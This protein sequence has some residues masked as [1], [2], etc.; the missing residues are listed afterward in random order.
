MHLPPPVDPLKIVIDENIPFGRE[1][2]GTLAAVVSLPGRA[3]EPKVVR[4]AEILVVRS[5]TQVDAALLQHS[6][7][8]FVGTATAGCDHIDRDYLEKNHILF[9]SAEGANAN[10]VAEYVLAALLMRARETETPLRGLSLGIIGVGHI[11]TR[12][13][14]KAAAI[15]MDIILNDPP[16]R[17]KTG[18]ACYRSFKEACEADFITL[19]VPLIQE[20][21]DTTRNLFDEA[22]IEKLSP[23]TLVVNTS[24]GEVVDN[25]AFLRAVIRERLAPPVFDVWENEPAINWA[26]LRQSGISTPHIAGYSLDGKIAGTRQI[27]EALCAALGVLPAWTSRASSLP[28]AP[29]IELDAANRDDLDILS[30]L[31]AQAYDL[32]G[33]VRRFKAVLTLPF[34]GRP[35]AFDQLR[36]TYPPR[37]EFQ[38]AQLNVR[39]AAPALLS[40]ISGLGFKPVSA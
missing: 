4:D 11:G 40:Q 33:D 8:Q 28:A 26:F 27:Y 21:P 18:F 16:L 6:A 30:G 36:K 35:A 31:T 13:A 22:A 39:H 7:V 3:I 25:A 32:A 1:A 29:L 37:R 14:E 12:V 10:S 24:R 17:R 34:E 38:S 5:V 23:E 2:F 9:A 19:H 15:G 20:G